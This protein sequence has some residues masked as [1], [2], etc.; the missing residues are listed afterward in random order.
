MIKRNKDSYVI[1]EDDYAMELYYNYFYESETWEDPENE[2]LEIDKVQLQSKLTRQDGIEE[3]V[4]TDITG[5]YFQQLDTEAIED[6][7]LQKERDNE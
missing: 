7:I 1:E 2:I 6:Q 3:W 4:T 5:F